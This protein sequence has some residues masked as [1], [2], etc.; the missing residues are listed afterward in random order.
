M[1]KLW[2]KIV[3]ILYSLPFGLKAADT[4]IMGSNVSGDGNDTVVQQQ[5]SDKRVAKHLLKGEITQ[6]VEELRYRTYKASREADNY[7]YVGHGI[8]IKKDKKENKSNVIKFSQ[9]NKLIC[10]DILTELKHVGSYGMERYLINID[11]LY[12]VRI[13]MQEHLKSVDVFIKEGEQAVTTLHFDD[14]PNPQKFNSKPFLNEL[15]KLEMM[16]NNNDTYGL[17]RSDY[18]SLVVGMNFTTFRATDDQPDVVSYSFLKPELIGVHHENGE[19]KLLYQWDKYEI[20]DL[21]KKFYNAELEEKYRKKEKKE[22][23]SPDTIVDNTEAMKVDDWWY[24]HEGLDYKCCRCGKKIQAFKD[25]FFIDKELNE[26]VC[27][28]CYTKAL[29]NNIV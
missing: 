18:V 19:Y 3:N 9:E 4:E 21:T 8:A 5:V 13:K 15:S 28:E 14:I 1:S 23:I 6:E 12:T 7:K 29:Q 22:T 16:F 2:D 27:L 24:K 10:E 11:Y 17:S 20:D 26:P 25:G